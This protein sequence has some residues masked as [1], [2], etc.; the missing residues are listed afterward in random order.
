MNIL[1]A[2]RRERICLWT[3]CLCLH[4]P[5]HNPGS[6][7]GTKWPAP[8][9]SSFLSLFLSYNSII[10]GKDLECFSHTTT[11]R[12]QVLSGTHLK[13]IAENKCCFCLLLLKFTYISVGHYK[14]IWLL[15]YSVLYQR[16]YRHGID[17]IERKTTASVF[18]HLIPCIWYFRNQSTFNNKIIPP[19]V[20]RSYLQNEF[21]SFYLVGF[22]FL[23]LAPL[24]IHFFQLFSQIAINMYISSSRN[25]F[26]S[27]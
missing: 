22:K 9:A 19:R 3:H 11:H 6:R 17:D 15:F 10:F 8:L 12:K 5:K 14:T 18:F 1:S 21:N 2:W 13:G 24:S 26:M 7:A 27:S 25:F 23:I 4:C 20:W 16:N